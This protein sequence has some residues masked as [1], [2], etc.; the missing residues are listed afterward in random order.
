MEDNVSW[1]T[2]GEEVSNLHYWATAGEEE[3]FKQIQYPL[4]T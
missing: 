1:K 3:D 2:L 4:C